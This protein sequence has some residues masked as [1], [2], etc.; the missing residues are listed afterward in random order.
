MSTAWTKSLVQQHA[1]A[2]VSVELYTLPFYFTALSSIK[3]TGH[4][5]YTDILGV[6]MEE[7]LHLQLAA[8][9]CL[10]LDAKPK[11]T[12]PIYGTTIPFLKPDDPATKHYSLINA[13][14]GALDQTTLQTMLDIETPEEFQIKDKHEPQTVYNSISQMYAALLA[15]IE[16]VGTSKFS[17]STTNQ[18]MF[19]SGQD[20]K[21]HITDLSDAKNAIDTIG[22]QGEGKASSSLPVAPFSETDFPI[23]SKHQLVNEGFDTKNQ[24]SHYGRFIHIQNLGTFPA[25]YQLSESSPDQTKALAKLKSD[26]AGVITSLNTLWD[27]G[28]GNIWSMTSLLADAE[29][30]WKAGVV[31]KWS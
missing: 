27:G 21:Q 7:M 6:C 2:A 14:L 26:F 15:G 16:A 8:N 3:D 23:P 13:K 17:W 25:V 4:T 24:Y 30:C 10:A 5:C 28:G 18:Q 19:W 12:V 29:A 1:Q 11:F 31:P 20:F 22:E 9:L